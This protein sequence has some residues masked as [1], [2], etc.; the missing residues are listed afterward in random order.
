MGCVVISF[1]NIPE[2]CQKNIQ[3]YPT[4][5]YVTDNRKHRNTS[6][7]V[8]ATS[9]TTNTVISSTKAILASNYYHYYYYYY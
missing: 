4:Q 1:L 2:K 5:M 9:T 6:Q 8:T 3:Y 7:T